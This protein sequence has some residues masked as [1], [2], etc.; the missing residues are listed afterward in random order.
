[1]S[2]GTPKWW[3]FRVPAL[4]LIALFAPPVALV[5]LWLSPLVA[6][7]EKWLGSIGIP[8]F[9]I[10][11]VSV[12]VWLLDVCFDVK[13]Y[14]WRGGYTPV[15]TFSPTTPDDAAVEA[16]RARQPRAKMPAAT[17]LFSDS[18]WPG[19]R[20]RDR[21][22]HVR[23][24]IRTNW[25]ATGL[26]LLWRQP[27]GGGYASFAIAGDLAFT[28]EQRRALEVVTAY[29]V[30]TGREVW[31]HEWEAR[32]AESIGGNGPRATP[33]LAD[34][35]LYALGGRGELRCLEARDGALLWRRDI[36]KENRAVE[37]KYGVSASPLLV[38]DKVIVLAGGTNG[39]SVIAYHRLTGEPVWRALDDPAAYVSP[40]LVTLAGERQLL[41]VLARRTVGLA[42]ADG[43]LLWEFA[44]G[45]PL[46]AR[47]VAQPVVFDGDKFVL[48]AGYDVGATAVQITRTG[49]GFTARELWHNRFLKNKFT[50]SVFHAGHL[51]GLDE[52]ILTCLDAT[53]GERRWKDGRYG[54]GQMLLV[55]ANLVILCGNGDLALV[56]ATPDAHQEIARVPGIKG[57][58]WN[59]PALAHGRLLL[60]NAV[61]M[62][63]F[64]ISPR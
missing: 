27:I 34:G 3:H 28:I 23:E 9:G 63:C 12:A 59:H 2:D 39:S 20:G 32:F 42:V 54:Y 43:R 48:S 5:C 56:R 29:D 37:L 36:V 13:L 33:T 47:N 62:A 10:L 45:E 46:L 61:E 7:R 21:D 55:G 8:I 1:M 4:R 57:T 31:A 64:D 38:E 24:P 51:Y 53:I 30:A 22:G 40:M 49:D 18:P 58:T 44:W 41:V 26:P 14:E 25:P 11:Y 15:I 17:N 19:F 50:S 35:R 52:E 60:R 16:H 6:R